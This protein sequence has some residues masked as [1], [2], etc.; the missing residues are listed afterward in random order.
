MLLRTFPVTLVLSLLDKGS[1]RDF[2]TYT[3]CP[4]DSACERI[5]AVMEFSPLGT[6]N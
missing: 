1:C 4:S 3:D 5:L 2:V 6:M